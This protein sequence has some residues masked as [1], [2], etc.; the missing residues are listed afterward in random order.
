MSRYLGKMVSGLCL[1]GHFLATTYG[2][3]ASVENLSLSS[4]RSLYVCLKEYITDL[5]QGQKK[6]KKKLK[7]MKEE[8]RYTALILAELQCGQRGVEKEIKKLREKITRQT[9]ETRLQLKMLDWSIQQ[10]VTLLEAQIQGLEKFDQDQ[11][12]ES[13]QSSFFLEEFSDDAED[14]GGGWF[15]TASSSSNGSYGELQ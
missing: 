3:E 8:Q 12:E 5:Q 14:A 7:E 1:L 11:K 9:Y 4:L 15:V 6:Q 13:V 10:E 2:M